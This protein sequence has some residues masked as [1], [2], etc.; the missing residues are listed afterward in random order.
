MIDLID[1]WSIGLFEIHSLRKFKLSTFGIGLK[2]T[3]QICL[4][5][6]SVALKSVVFNNNEKQNEAN[7]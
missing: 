7:S 5:I 6:S 4:N 3:K 1:C 2:K